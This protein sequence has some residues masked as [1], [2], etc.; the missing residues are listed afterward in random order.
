MKPSHPMTLP[1]R[2]ALPE[3]RDLA[4]SAARYQAPPGLEQA[5]DV[6]VAL[7]VPLLITGDPGTGKTQAA[8]H[9]ARRYGVDSDRIFR[10]D[11]DSSTTKGDLTAALDT[12]AYFHAANGLGE[13][14]GPLDPAAFYLEGPLYKAYRE[15][16]RGSVVLI[17]EIDKA[18]RTFPNDLLNTIDRHEFLIS[19]T[20]DP[21]RLPDDAPT[22]LI[23][24]TSNTERRL[25]E[26]FLR[27]CIYC[28]IDFSV[29]LLRRAVDAH[30][31]DLRHDALLTEAAI[32]R[33]LELRSDRLDLSKPP[34]TSELL[35]WLYALRDL[36][37]IDGDALLEA[38]LA[39]LPV[40]AAL[41]KTREDLELL[42]GL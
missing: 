6:A 15:A 40:L 5:S 16:H 31:S 3:F 8:Y 22:P 24:I 21:V 33:F 28:H 36:D 32:A 19:E 35:H 34:S 30:A 20:R 12:V 9:L 10:L 1:T 37:G 38:P 41:I 17:D 13:Q 7:G 42:R 11:V 23:V 39:E 26:P 4:K 14:S 18:S 2:R 27:R 25:P 29:E